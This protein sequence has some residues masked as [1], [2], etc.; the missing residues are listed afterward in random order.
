MQVN[1]PMNDQATAE[2]D[3]AFD[4]ICDR[5]EAA[6]KS[7][8]EPMIEDFLTPTLRAEPR[9]A[10][11]LLDELVAIDDE[12]RRRGS[13]PADR[14][15]L[16]TRFPELLEGKTVSASRSTAGG[17]EPPVA[18][19]VRLDDLRFH[20]R[21]G[22]GEVYRA[23]DPK[24]HRDVAVKFIRHDLVTDDLRD[25][26][27][28][29][30]EITGRLD[31]PGVVPLYGLG[32]SADGRPFIAMRFIE[33]RTLKS[34]IAEFHDRGPARPADRRRELNRLLSHLISAC[35][36]VGYAHSRGIIHR[37]I[38][39]DNIMIGRFNE[40]LVVDWGLAV[41]IARDERARSSGEQTMHL[42]AASTGNSGGRLAA[43]T[44]GYVSPEATRDGQPDIDG[45]SD[46]YSLGATLHHLLTGRRSIE[47]QP[48]REV[49]E[50]IRSGAVPSPR[51][52]NR[53]VSRQLDA[54]CRK[55]MA[56][57]KEARYA[58]PTELAA[59]LEACIADE[60]VGVLRQTLVDRLRRA[61][62]S[63]RTAVA[64]ALLGLVGTAVLSVGSAVWL[65]RQAVRERAAFQAVE[66]A[67]RDSLQLAAGFAARTVGTEIDVRWRILESMAADREL[68]RLLATAGASAEVKGRQDLQ[69]WLAARQ[70]DY[71]DIRPDSWFLTDARGIQVGRFPA[72]AGSLGGDFS[73]RDYFHG[74]GH[75]LSAGESATP[76]RSPHVSTSYV[77]ANDQR[78]KIAF[79]VP[80]WG[81]ED[82]TRAGPPVGVLG[83]SMPAGGFRIL[84]RGLKQGQVAVLVDVRDSA[85]PGQ[86]SKRGQ[87][88]HHPSLRSAQLKDIAEEGR[89]RPV[90]VDEPLVAR[91]D[92]LRKVR[93]A[94]FDDEEPAPMIG[95]WQAGTIPTAINVAAGYPGTIPAD[96]PGSWLAAF[97]PVLITGRP[98][99]LRDSGL[100]VIVQQRTQ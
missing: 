41:P 83:M 18:L 23:R 6:W 57:S 52:V 51:S 65:E 46:V 25:R 95:P 33:G 97:E 82:E 43:G 30:A 88:L 13:M 14:N 100:V 36:T 40:T 5:F 87:V 69:D 10:R 85:G 37:D 29:E 68:R 74:R 20:A 12:Y 72:S 70:G 21:G 28:V 59:D 26:F 84:Q 73:G 93:N 60:P 71:V 55:A 34:V 38:K 9:F 50:A 67:N 42:A 81:P 3:R 64:A 90:Y 58:S 17:T 86:A 77:S 79:T 49:L 61:A 63:H 96:R 16:A 76:I 75:E 80:V 98:A 44:I 24:L 1:R 31:H 56:P 99:D 11:R 7:G 35:H 2:E 45:R 32:E 53:R 78:I 89:P 15:D 62:R 4:A 39:P 92:A 54:V 19:E 22:L 27:V 48:S 94:S 47:G 91:L 8:V 66:S